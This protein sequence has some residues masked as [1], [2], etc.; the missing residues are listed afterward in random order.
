MKYIAHK[1]YTVQVSDCEWDRRLASKV[2]T[3]ETSMKELLEWSKSIEKHDYNKHDNSPITIYEL[4]HEK[5]IP[6]P[7][8][9][10]N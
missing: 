5:A 2:I 10:E 7:E 6:A 1:N 8:P 3:D 4:K 9:S